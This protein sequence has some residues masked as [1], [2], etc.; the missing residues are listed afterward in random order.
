MTVT[1]KNLPAGLTVAVHTALRNAVDTD[2]CVAGIGPVDPKPFQ[3][4]TVQDWL[5][6]LDLLTEAC[7]TAQQ[8][9]RKAVSAGRPGRVVFIVHPPTA[10]A[11]GTAT[12]SVASTILRTFAQGGGIPPAV[13]D[14]TF[15]VVVAEWN[16]AP[17]GFPGT[18]PT[19]HGAA[20]TEIAGAIAYLASP[21]ARHITGATLNV[22][23]IPA[24]TPTRDDGPAP[25][26]YTD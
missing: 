4:I 15:N 12:G 2:V 18:G 8:A 19:V 9:A 21:A 26:D 7:F 13:G 10:R 11:A 3:D 14:V 17:P 5:V 24:T 6:Q 1:V 20:D 23:G 22:D 16:A 25:G